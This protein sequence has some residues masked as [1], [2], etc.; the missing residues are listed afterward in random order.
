MPSAA[1]GPIAVSNPGGTVQLT[2]P[3]TSSSGTQHPGFIVVNGPSTITSIEDRTDTLVLRGQN[4]PRVLGI[5]I[6]LK[7][8]P[9]APSGADHQFIRGDFDTRND[10]V[11]STEMRVPVNTT[12]SLIEPSAIRLWAPTVPP[13]DYAPLLSAYACQANPGGV[14]WP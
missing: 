12:R 7:P 14:Q 5:C 13:G 1:S 10:A 4:L 8:N 3:F 9:G 11:T 2:G 6:R